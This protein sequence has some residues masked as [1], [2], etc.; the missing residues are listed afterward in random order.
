[1]VRIGGRWVHVRRS[2]ERARPRC[3]DASGVREKE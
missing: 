2:G 1:M 3:V